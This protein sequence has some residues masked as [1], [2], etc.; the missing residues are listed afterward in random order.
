LNAADEVAVNSFIQKEIRFIDLPI[1]IEK[2]LNVHNV[3]KNPSLDDIMM[4][5]L[6]ARTE[7]KK[8]IERMIS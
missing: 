8:I 7:T 5:D 4:T 2:A 1:I 6:W 3:I